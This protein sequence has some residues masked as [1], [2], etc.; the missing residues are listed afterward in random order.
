MIA[1]PSRAL[2]GI[3]LLAVFHASH[4]QAAPSQPHV[5]EVKNMAFGPPPQDLHVGDVVKWVNH[6]LVEHTATATDGSFDVTLMPDSSGE[7]Q[8]K[9]AGRISYYCRFHPGMKG[10]LDVAP[11]K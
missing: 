7:A 5:L 11:A 3:A 9:K 2:T 4:A 10:E 8:L 1:A 6:D